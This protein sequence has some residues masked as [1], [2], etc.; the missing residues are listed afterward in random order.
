M[1]IIFFGWIIIRQRP[2]Q[3]KKTLEKAVSYIQNGGVVYLSMEGRR[4]KTGSLGLY[5]KGP[6]VLAI[7]ANAKIIP[8]I[9]QGS[10]KCLSYGEW[11]IK[12]GK[13]T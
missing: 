2:K 3:A 5:K 7:Q 8:S 13:V 11:K 1:D 9:I 10:S 4:S 12:S 6:V